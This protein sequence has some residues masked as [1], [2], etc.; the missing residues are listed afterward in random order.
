M[1]L[2]GNNFETHEKQNMIWS[3]ANYKYQPKK[4]QKTDTY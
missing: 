1:Q 2:Y 4:K 3:N